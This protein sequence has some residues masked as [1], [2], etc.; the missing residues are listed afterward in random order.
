MDHLKKHIREIPDFPVEGILF[1]DITTL[2]ENPAVFG[3]I[4]ASLCERYAGEKIDKIAA[5]ESR[6]FIFATPVARELGVGF[7]PLR[8]PGKLPYK[9]IS[10]SYA[11]EYGKATI[12]VHE[13]AIKPGERVL[14][15]DDLLATGGT[16]AAALELIQKMGGEVIEAGFVI[17]L[18]G[19]KG[20]EKL[21][22]VPVYSMVS[23][24]E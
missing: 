8:K 7:V 2:L 11:L 15:L 22:Q 14:I 24:D 21:G 18:A 17:E 19:L 5:M 1:Y 10:V 3:E 16:A 6:G 4:I 13:D 23:Y 12:E 20:R 9:T